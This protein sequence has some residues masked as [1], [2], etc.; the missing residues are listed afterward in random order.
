MRDIHR[1][2]EVVYEIT[3]KGVPFC[4]ITKCKSNAGAWD[5]FFLTEEG[6]SDDFGLSQAD[7]S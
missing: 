6:V 4:E 3:R 7:R 2:D 1:D 5:S